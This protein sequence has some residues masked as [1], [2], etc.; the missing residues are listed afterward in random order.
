[1]EGEI[2]KTTPFE[3]VFIIRDIMC[4]DKK[5]M[6]TNSD[7]LGQTQEPSYR[8]D[9]RI[10]E[11]ILDLGDIRLGVQVLDVACGAGTR[12]PAY[13]S[14]G[15]VRIT[16][17]DTSAKALAQAE[18]QFAQPNVH[19]IRAD[20]HACRFDRAFDRCIVCNALEEFPDLPRLLRRLADFVKPGG[21]LTLAQRL[22]NP[23]VPLP[24]PDAIAAMLADWFVVDVR[25]TDNE[26]YVVSGL[27]NDIPSSF[28][29]LLPHQK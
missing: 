26:L 23:S 11:K 19:L 6:A 12:F 14:R 2:I 16:G 24:E 13:L 27:R 29:A 25:H 3:M 10:T 20:I 21:R 4:A 9:E 28:M 15:V 22:T 7:N 17:V 18:K 5:S 8:Y 1:M